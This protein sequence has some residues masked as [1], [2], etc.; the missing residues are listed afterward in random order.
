MASK[1]IKEVIYTSKTVIVSKSSK[2]DHYAITFGQV[3][4]M[5]SLIGAV[6]AV[7]CLLQVSFTFIVDWLIPKRIP[8]NGVAECNRKAARL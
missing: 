8:E 1:P 5:L 6:T 4:Q 3:A 2:A 7:I